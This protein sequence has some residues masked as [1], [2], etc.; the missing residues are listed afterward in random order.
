MKTYFYEIKEPYQAIIKAHDEDEVL[1]V[2]EKIVADVES[3]E[4]F[5]QELEVISEDNVRQQLV[6]C[7]VDVDSTR[8]MSAQEQEEAIKS[9]APNLILMEVP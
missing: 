6:N 2:Y 3:E 8:L 9:K 4:D 7:Y 5:F 1:K